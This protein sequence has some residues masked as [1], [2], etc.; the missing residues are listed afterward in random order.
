MSANETLRCLTCKT[1]TDH[2]RA[3][4]FHP[5]MVARQLFKPRKGEELL[6]HI[7]Y[8]ERPGGHHVF[9]VICGPL[10]D[11]RKHG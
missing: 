8:I 9:P 7:T 4:P 6:F 10:M 2:S 3:M 11:R 5:K 1:E